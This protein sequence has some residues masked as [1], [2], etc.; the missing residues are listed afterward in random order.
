MLKWTCSSSFSSCF[1]ECPF[2][3]FFLSSDFHV[4][5]ISTIHPAVSSTAPNTTFECARKYFIIF[6]NYAICNSRCSYKF[7]SLFSMF[8]ATS[9]KT[10]KQFLSIRCNR[11]F[12]RP[13]IFQNL[14]KNFI[15]SSCCI[16]HRISIQ[17]VSSTAIGQLIFVCCRFHSHCPKQ[18]HWMTRRFV[19]SRVTQFNSIAIWAYVKSIRLI[20]T[21][22][23]SICNDEE[24]KFNTNIKLS[25]KCETKRF[26]Y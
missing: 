20:S 2:Y 17:F 3:C 11:N 16:S 21:W 4:I 26:K 15:R 13:I 18:F 14:L 1:R 7:V 12:F 9:F 19:A 10:T 23:W 25:Y 22:N 6:F 8:H 5:I 24:K